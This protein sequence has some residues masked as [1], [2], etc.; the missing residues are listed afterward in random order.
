MGFNMNLD[1]GRKVNTPSK[2]KEGGAVDCLLQLFHCFSAGCVRLD[3]LENSLVLSW[4]LCATMVV[5]FV[6]F[7]GWN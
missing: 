6:S 1:L 5:G 3:E 2:P 7:G 4:V